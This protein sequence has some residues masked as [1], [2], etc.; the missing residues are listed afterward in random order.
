[1]ASAVRWHYGRKLEL[2]PFEALCRKWMFVF[3][4]LEAMFLLGWVL[5]ARGL[6]DDIG[7]LGPALDGK[8]H[9]VQI[10]GF[11]A[12]LGFPVA[13]YAAFKMWSQPGTW[14]FSRVRYT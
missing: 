5:L 10:L 4:I 13:L 3:C 9:V 8:Q 6:T 7:S 2:S 1:I 11:L 14:W 12:A